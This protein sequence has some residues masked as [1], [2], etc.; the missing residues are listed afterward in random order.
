M[1]TADYLN[2]LIDCKEDMKSAIEEKGATV[3]GGLTSYA[4]AIERIV[5]PVVDVE[6]FDG[7]WTVNYSGSELTEPLVL[8]FNDLQYQSG[9][10]GIAKFQY[11]DKIISCPMVVIANISDIT[12]FKQF[13]TYLNPRTSYGYKDLTIGVLKN[14]IMQ[15]ETTQIN[16]LKTIGYLITTYYA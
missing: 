5:P 11:I 3:T 9:P 1:T 15:L 4:D 6:M 10:E 16:Y 14:I 7:G 13:L 2:E 12:K 8:D